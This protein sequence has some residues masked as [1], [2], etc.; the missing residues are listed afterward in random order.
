MY[1]YYHFVNADDDGDDNDSRHNY[2][3]NYVN[4]YDDYD[5]DGWVSLSVIFL[6]RYWRAICLAS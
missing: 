6:D 5:Y 2:D 3:E 1:G 4:N